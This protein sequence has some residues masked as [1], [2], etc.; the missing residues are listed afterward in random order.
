VA[1]AG[2]LKSLNARFRAGGIPAERRIAGQGAVF[3]CAVLWSASG[4]CIKLVDWHPAQIAGGRSFL[5]ALVLLLPRLVSRGRAAASANIPLS[6]VS[7]LCYALTMILFVFANKLTAP[8][9]AIVLQYTAPVWTCLLAWFFL[10][11]R[12]RREHWAALAVV[13]GGMFLVF[14]SGL[15]GGSLRG[16]C[17]ALA[18][19]LCFGANTV[20]MRARKDG[21]PVDIMIAAHV[22]T[23]VCSIPFFA[24]YPPALSA[25]AAAGILFMGIFQLGAASALFAY[26][27]RRVSAVQ[28]MLIAAVEPVLNPVWVL[29]VTGERPAP[30]VIAGGSVIVAAAVFSALLGRER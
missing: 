9:N 20:V 3:L 8:A 15:A 27:I 14:R 5:A 21:N 1:H 7:G 11:E 10:G 4:L 29:L 30:P 17:L 12:P 25:G 23:A 6:A 16:D 24:L 18:S 28:A 22:I 26:G 2:H 19:G 13:G